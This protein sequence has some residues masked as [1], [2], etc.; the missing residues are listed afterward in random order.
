[1]TTAPRRTGRGKARP[2]R[3]PRPAPQRGITSDYALENQ[4]GHLLRRAHQRHVAL[5]AEHIG[6][7]GFTPTQWAALAKL[8]ELG[9]ASQNQLG[10]LTAIDAATLQGLVQRLIRRGILVQKQDPRDRR[11]NMLR[12]TKAGIAFVDSTV[13]HAKRIT[14]MTLAPL[15]QRERKEFVRLLRLLT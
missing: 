14:R 2:L 12:L 4:V 3:K 10:R 6:P 7:Q 8:R 9:A 1:M 15:P 13:A 5:F 11:R